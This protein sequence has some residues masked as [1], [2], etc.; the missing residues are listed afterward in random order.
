MH[1]EELESLQSKSEVFE[2]TVRK[3]PV[4]EKEIS[5]LKEE[6]KFLRFALLVCVKAG[7]VSLHLKVEYVVDSMIIIL[8]ESTFGHT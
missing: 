5:K 8:R 6:N 1:Q 2:T 7:M 3:L 4:L